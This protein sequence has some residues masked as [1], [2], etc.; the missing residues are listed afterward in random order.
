M[1]DDLL[2]A[3]SGLTAWEM[4]FIGDLDN[5][6]GRKLTEKQADALKRAWERVCT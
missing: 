3:E 4:D 1:L 6:R 5:R 2:D